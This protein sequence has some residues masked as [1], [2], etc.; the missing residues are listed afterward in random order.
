MNK[1][2]LLYWLPRVLGILYIFFVSMFALDVFEENLGFWGT[3]VALFM[4]LI[5]SFILT[6]ML[7]IAWKF[8]KTG[9]LVF[10]AGG[11]IL[12]IL[13]LSMRNGNNIGIV[14]AWAL[15]LFTPL[16]IIGLLFLCQSNPKIKN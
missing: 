10:L 13:Y 1:A 12:L 6:A 8:K 16:F 15:Q 5:P 14:F 7:V 3:T 9:A 2:K 4:H 11:V